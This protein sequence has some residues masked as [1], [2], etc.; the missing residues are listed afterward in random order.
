MEVGLSAD[1][2]KLH[3]QSIVLLPYHPGAPQQRNSFTGIVT[4]CDADT[5][6]DPGLLTTDHPLLTRDQKVRSCEPEVASGKATPQRL[7][8]IRGAVQCTG[9]VS[10]LAFVGC[11]GVLL[12]SCIDA[13]V[14][15]GV[16]M[17]IVGTAAGSGSGAYGNLTLCRRLITAFKYPPIL[18][19]PTT[20]SQ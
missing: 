1:V 10:H 18:T 3:P 6:A 14:L 8:F 12:Y 19:L 15:V 13:Y 20:S 4:P 5:G 2:A 7:L 11:R 9:R 17:T 16:H